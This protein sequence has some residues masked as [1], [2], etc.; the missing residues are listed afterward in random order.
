MVRQKFLNSREIKKIREQV[1]KQFNY[2]PEGDYAFVENDKGRLFIIT[3][4]IAKIEINNL[5][6]DKYGL[7]FA[8]N[9]PNN[10]RL[11]K[12]GAQLLVR[13]GKKE[14][15]N[16]IE[17]NETEV[18]SYFKGEDLKKDLGKESKLIIL[19]HKKDILGCAKYK[20]GIILNF[21]PKIHRGTV[22]V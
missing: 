1:I 17:I 9:K 5:R 6:I 15:S 11:S 14:V 22:I 18:E 13:M 7:Y 10:I 2:F 20:E 3:K 4:N 8:E 12:E 19:K 21:L 16:V